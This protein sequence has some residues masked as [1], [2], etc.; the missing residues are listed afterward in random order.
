MSILRSPSCYYKGVKNIIIAGLIFIIV[1]LAAVVFWPDSR[2]NQNAKDSAISPASQ[3]QKSTVSNLDLSGKNLSQI[4]KDKLD[5]PTIITLNVSNNNLTGSLPAEIR[6]LTNLESLD[7]S[8]NR[9]SGI[10]AEIGQLIKLK[11]VNY[12]NNDL[13]GLPMEIGNLNDLETFDLRGNPKLSK[14]DL[15]KI[16]SKIPNARFL[17]D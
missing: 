6:K 5:N 14:S 2:N 1:V 4:D 17:T 16:Q 7:A 12:A 10:P 15:S 13:S 3:S 8:N 11:T 9:M